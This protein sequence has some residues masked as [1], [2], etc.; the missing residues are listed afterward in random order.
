VSSRADVLIVTATQTESRQV[1]EVFEKAGGRHAKPIPI[2]DRIYFDLGEING[3][4]ASMVQCPTMGTAS[5]GASLQ[6]VEKGIEALG[7][8]AV[9]MVGIGFGVNPKTQKIGDILVAENLRYYELERV[10]TDRNRRKKITRSDRP[11]STP[12]ASESP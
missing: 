5:L 6:T 8:S 3:A 2:G 4:R 11:S 10:G 12:L 1:L 7:P 9:I